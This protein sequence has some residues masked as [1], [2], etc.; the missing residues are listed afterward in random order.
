MSFEIVVL[1]PRLEEVDDSISKRTSFR[2]CSDG[3]GI[4]GIWAYH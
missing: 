1:P 2:F 3:G 4:F